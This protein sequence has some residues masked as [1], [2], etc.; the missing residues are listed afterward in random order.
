MQPWAHAQH[1][2]GSGKKS[3]INSVQLA[4]IMTKGFIVQGKESVMSAIG[5]IVAAAG[6]TG[7]GIVAFSAPHSSSAQSCD[8][9]YI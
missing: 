3:R 2:T 8:P 9:A 5:R 7:F 1:V 4:A 6:V